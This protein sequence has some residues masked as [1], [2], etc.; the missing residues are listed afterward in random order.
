MDVA[1]SIEVALQPSEAFD[2]IVDELA[3][4]LEKSGLKFEGRPGGLVTEGQLQ[5]GEIENWIAGSRISI[6]W[7]PKSW[8][9]D[10]Q[11]RLVI[12]FERD[13]EGTRVTITSQDWDRI[14]GDDGK[15]L[16]G[17]FAGEIAAPLML[18]L[19]PKH[20]GDWITDRHGRSPS[21]NRSRETYRNPIYHWPNFLAILNVLSLKPEDYLLE[22]GCG[23][24]AF[25]HEALKSGCRAAAIDHSADMIRVATDAN[26]E[27]I[28]EGRLVIEKSEADSLPYSDG[29]FT[30]AVMTGVFGFIDDP[31]ACFKEIFRTLQNGGRLVVFTSTKELAGTP[32]A[33]EPVA[34]R[35]HFYEDSELENLA[36]LVGFS[37]ARVDHPS[38]YKYAKKV[39]VPEETLDLFKGTAYSQLLIAKK[40]E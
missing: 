6:A 40:G 18:A 21:G 1:A 30:C 29:A 3:L 23:G 22:V 33:P 25:L 16:L 5:V 9:E 13:G 38:F 19:T 12:S 7:H 37:S 39:G 36:R 11:N 34:S 10:Q 4:S 14:L 24:G 35:L 31:L 32:A 20:L 17:W 15:E 8:Q 27:A 28:S 26:R 2:S